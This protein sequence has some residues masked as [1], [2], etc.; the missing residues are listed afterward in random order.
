MEAITAALAPQINPA[1][2]MQGT[3]HVLGR[4]N[5]FGWISDHGMMM[6]DG[7][8]PPTRIIMRP[9]SA[10]LQIANARTYVIHLVPSCIS[11]DLIT[12]FYGFIYW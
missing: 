4:L 1:S 3:C 9:A 2:N 12:S 11:K 8:S 10:P 7:I 6:A 5:I